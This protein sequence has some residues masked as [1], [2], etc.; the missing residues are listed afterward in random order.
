M[1]CMPVPTFRLLDGRIG[2]DEKLAT[3]LVGLQSVGGLVLAPLFPGSVSPADVLP[4]FLPPRLAHGGTRCEW[5]LA[6]RRGLGRLL[7]ATTCTTGDC[8]FEPWGPPL[9]QPVSVASDCRQ[10]FVADRGAEAGVLLDL[11][12]TVRTTIPVARPGP[13][14]IAPWGELLVASRRRLLRFGPGGDSRGAIGGGLG[15][16]VALRA[17]YSAAPQ[18][19]DPAEIW[20]VHRRGDAF[21]LACF[22][23]SGHRLGG[24]PARLARGFGPMGIGAWDRNGFC[25][26][27][28][29][30]PRAPCLDW[31][32]CPTHAEIAAFPARAREI[33]GRLVIHPLDATEPRTVW[34]RIQL[35][36]DVPVGT[37]VIVEF[38]TL[39][40]AGQ[41]VDRWQPAPAGS[42]DFLV[43]ALPGRYLALRLTLRGDG[44]LTP[45]VRSARVD[46][47][48]V[49]SADL[50]PAVYREEPVASDFTER[51][52]AL[53]DAELEKI[54][55]VIE[56]F[57]ATVD[58]RATSDA[59]L[60][61][62][63]SLVGLTFDDTW[64]PERRRTLLR[65]APRLFARRGTP[66][67][68]AR[69]LEIASGDRPALVEEPS[70]FG[71]LV[72]ASG[73]AGRPARVGAVRLFGRNRRRFRLDRSRTGQAALRS[74]GNPDA[75]PL[76]ETAYRFAVMF[77]PGATRTEPERARLVALVEALKPAH[78]LATVR[79]GGGGM[80]LGALSVAG[81][82]TALL[83]PPPPILGRTS[84][85]SRFTIVWPSAR[86]RGPG[87]R[88]DYPVLGDT[89]L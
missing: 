88:L 60:P 74:Y 39:D 53:F 10:V 42:R 22:D 66:W 31:R 63:A 84:R 14:A 87:L 34:H 81:I 76:Q 77:P 65:E 46:F 36:A 1:S 20:V 11:A 70:P 4:Y 75:D 62:L 73:E 24:G 17:G 78:A 48:R 80:V 41:A 45:R 56:R 47:P 25:W 64:T 21:F 30:G 61:W 40:R 38:A 89:S 13:V 44:A 54:D 29:R 59:Y 6:P 7:R 79:F 32:G 69:V 33:E 19:E 9:L 3:G 86:A 57:P 12:A 55:R 52:T 71:A 68:L 27:D 5:L 50:L 35:D 83:P 2:W 58:P 18:M 28:P 82:D 16:I 51:F 85:L 67:S 72:H 23:R 49:T 15:W 8:P 43:Q 37:E 26:S